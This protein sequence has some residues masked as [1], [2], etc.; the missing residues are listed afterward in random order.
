[1]HISKQSIQLNYI[2]KFITKHCAA[3]NIQGI[4]YDLF[5]L[6]LSH[7]VNLLLYELDE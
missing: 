4:L 5:Q 1:M 3:V 7:E 6:F 2:F